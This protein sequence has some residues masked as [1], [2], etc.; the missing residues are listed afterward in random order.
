MTDGWTKVW[1]MYTMDYY[2]AMKKN[3]FESGLV[4]W[5]KLEP[6]IQSEVSQKEKNAFCRLTHICIESTKI[7]LMNLFGGHE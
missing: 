4:R 6:V 5:M 2:S 1:Y 7:V 3:P